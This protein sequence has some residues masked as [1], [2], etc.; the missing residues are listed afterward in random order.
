MEFT[1]IAKSQRFVVKTSDGRYTHKQSFRGPKTAV[2]SIS[3]V[4]MIGTYLVLFPIQ[5]NEKNVLGFLT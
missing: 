4:K 3:T 2:V 1:S 5:E